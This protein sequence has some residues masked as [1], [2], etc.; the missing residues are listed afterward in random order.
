MSPIELL[1][2]AKKEGHDLIILANLYACAF[3]ANRWGNH[4][5]HK[6]TYG[7]SRSRI[8]ENKDKNLEDVLKSVK[9]IY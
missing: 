3:N 2:T 1:W 4:V 7:N 6:Q 5:R 9:L 8:K